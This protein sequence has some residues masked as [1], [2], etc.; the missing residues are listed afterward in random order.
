VPDN[1]INDR[2]LRVKTSTLR[3]ETYFDA[4]GAATS[5]EDQISPAYFLDFE[6]IQ[7]A[8]P[9]WKG[10]RPYQQLVFQYSL[11]RVE[12]DGTIH[13]SEFLDISGEDPREGLVKAMLKDCGDAGPIYVYFEGF[14]KTRIL[15]LAEAFPRHAEGLHALIPRIVDLL[16]IAR[17]HYYHPIQRGT[18]SLKAVLPA[19]CPE[20]KYSDL[21]EV[22]NGKEA[23]IAYLEAITTETTPERR[24]ILRQHMLEYCKL[25][26][27]ATVKIWQFFKGIS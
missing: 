13:H 21:K 5:L 20:L 15:E 16:P 19:I 6:S 22:Q 9:I 2:Q 11:H 18:W 3:G 23:G 24:E 12:A 25:D 4:A 27:L 8:V 14:E 7:F 26:T 10:T 17:N 1:E